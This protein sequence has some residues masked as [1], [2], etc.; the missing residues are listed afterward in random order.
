[1]KIFLC[2]GLITLMLVGQ[3]HS[4]L[5]MAQVEAARTK[6]AVEI[7]KVKAKDAVEK[8]PENAVLFL[9]SSSV[10]RWET[11]T[12]D[13]APYH[14][15]QRGYGGA[16]FADLVVFAEELITPHQFRALVVY[17][18]NDVVGKGTDATPEQVGD[19]FKTV[20]AVARAKQPGADVFCVEITPTPSRWKAQSK[21]DEVN[22]VLRAACEADPKLHFVQTSSA[23][24]NEAKQPRKE[25]FV[26][27][28][29]HQNAAGY[30]LWA[31]KIKA[32]LAAA[33]IPE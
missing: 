24:L 4:E 28:M 14:P 12:Q 17:V 3:V 15:I 7:A 19:W 9:G 33:G 20:A 21:I 6:W 26:K 10:R 18:G 2:T 23:Y 30:K 13:M 5:P 8:H 16:K 32:A 27:D 31:S 22:A 11:I 25:L 1:M 29:L